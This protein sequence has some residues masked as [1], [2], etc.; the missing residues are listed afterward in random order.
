VQGAQTP[1][2]ESA[3]LLAQQ[4]VSRLR[5][6]GQRHGHPKSAGPRAGT[7]RPSVRPANTMGS[8]PGPAQQ[9]A[10]GRLAWPQPLPT[11]G[12]N[13]PAAAPCPDAALAAQSISSCQ[14]PA[15][16]C[17][18]PFQSA[19]TKKAITP[20]LIPPPRSPSHTHT[21]NTCASPTHLSCMQRHTGR[22]RSCHQTRPACD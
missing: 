14:H 11:Y 5:Q 18:S 10:L 7:I 20:P 8:L 17:V 16:H 21:H 15:C 1:A 13:L 6:R 12:S 4:A 9:G 22:R 2:G 3:R 19:Q